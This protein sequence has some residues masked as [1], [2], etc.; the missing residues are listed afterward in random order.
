[1][2]GVDVRTVLEELEQGGGD[3]TAALAYVAVQSVDLDQAELLASRRRALL[4]LA[5]GGDPRRDLDPDSRAVATLAADLDTPARRT[6][7]EAALK[8]MRAK[9]AGL[10]GVAGALD[11][12]LSEPDLAWRWAGCAL[13]AEELAE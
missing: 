6:A 13:L 11:V 12:L 10:G 1:M 4:L 3:P 5:S 9:A 7:L 8:G 2:G